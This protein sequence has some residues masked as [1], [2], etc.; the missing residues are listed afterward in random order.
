MPLPKQTPVVSLSSCVCG[1]QPA[2][3]SAISVAATAYWV[4]FAMRRSPPFSTQSEACHL[5]SALLPG[6]TSPATVL[7]NSR[8]RGAGSRFVTLTMPLAL[9]RRRF[10]V[11]RMP[12]PRGVMAPMPVTTTRRIVWPCSPRLSM[13]CGQLCL[14]RLCSRSSACLVS[15]LAWKSP[16]ARLNY[17]GASDP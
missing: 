17:G 14:L 8:H 12:T 16:R 13:W 10:Q 11:C 6:G 3:T 7:G 2:S 5:P 4:N 9:A 1:R 15:C